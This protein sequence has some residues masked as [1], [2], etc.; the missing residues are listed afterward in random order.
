MAS[1]AGPRVRAGASPNGPRHFGSIAAEP[2]R[3]DS[4]TLPDGERQAAPIALIVA[5]GAIPGVVGLQF[6]PPQV[7]PRRTT[8][9]I[10]GRF[11]SDCEP[12]CSCK[13]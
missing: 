13:L 4:E 5:S 1:C 3:D 2:I 7:V 10:R 12:T 11:S 9:Q 8:T 6:P